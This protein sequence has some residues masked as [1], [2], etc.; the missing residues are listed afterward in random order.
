MRRVFPASVVACGVRCIGC[1]YDLSGFAS[2]GGVRVCPECGRGFDPADAVTFESS[3]FR[4][5]LLVYVRRVSLG[6]SSL[7]LVMAGSLQLARVVWRVEHG[8]WPE[9][10]MDDPGGAWWYGFLCLVIVFCGV[11]SIVG[12][13]IVAGGVAYV[14]ARTGWRG[15][16]LGAWCVL[17]AGFGVWVLWTDFFR[18]SDWFMD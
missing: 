4:R 14:A 16:V 8:R 3:E 15:C 9:P 13:P 11:G 6:L 12:V 17:L 2:E 18:V 10:Y 7:P 1:Q 5:A